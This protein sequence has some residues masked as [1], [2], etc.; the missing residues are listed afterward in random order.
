[1][2]VIQDQGGEKGKRES[3]EPVDPP[4]SYRDRIAT[5][6]AE[7]KRNFIHPKK[8]KGRKHRARFIVA[9]VLVAIFFAGPW[10]KIGGH[11]LLLLNVLERRFVILGQPFWPQ[12]FHLFFL[13]MIATIVFILLFTVVY[14]RLFCGWVCPQTVFLEMVFRKIEYWIDGDRVAQMKLRARPWDEVKVFKRLAKHG[15]FIFISFAV[16]NTFMA[17]LVGTDGF[18]ERVTQ[19]PNQHLGAFFGV[20]FF[21]GL[22]YFIFSWF[23]E[24]ACTLVCPYGRLQGVLL[25]KDSIVVNY[26]WVR[27]EPRTKPRYA[28]GKDDVGDCIDCSKC[29]QV[30]PT[31]I[32][33]RN[34]T[35]L[36]CVNCTACIDAC[37]SVMDA[38][39]KPRGLIRYASHNSIESGTPLKFGGRMVAYSAV[40]LILLGVLAFLLISRSDVETT[41]LRTP[42]M[43]YQPVDEDHVRNLYSLKMVNKT[44]DEMPVRLV[45]VEPEAGIVNLV[46][47]DLVI[48]SNNVIE[49]A[50]FV[51]L[52]INELEGVKTPLRIEVYSGDR[53]L[54][55]VKTSFMGPA[56]R[57]HD[58][59]HDEE[60]DD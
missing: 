32:D 24:Q 17:Y 44:F 15:I 36:E 54:E 42:G 46:G 35:Q 9:M 45:V 53:K 1:M 5:M 51:T 29:V 22:F 37:D 10:I 52:P 39:K 31:G 60:D 28:K 12:D 3:N 48:E 57:H 6:D 41:V 11:P 50:F 58:D 26:D 40:L 56:T 25:D 19:P 21:T 23:R 33:I 13:A 2:I 14:G 43:L 8:P 34:G 27:G 18:F 4:I 16:A 20:V 59:D 38:V 30:C 7:G 55:T 49:S 47:T